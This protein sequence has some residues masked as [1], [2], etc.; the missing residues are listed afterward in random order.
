MWT[1]FWDMHSGGGPKEKG[2]EKIYIEAPEEEAKIIFYNRFK[3]SPDRVSCTCCGRDYSA[4]SNESLAYL[5]AYHR[6]CK[7]SDA[8]NSY[9]E[10][11]DQNFNFL[12]DK[13]LLTLEEYEQKPDV[14]VIRA[15]DI[16]PEE[17]LGEVPEEGYVWR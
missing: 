10:E 4:E 9:V 17:R 11:P 7:W 14:L 8:T 13:K 6:G 15:A 2:Y 3:H 16:K 12:K 5:S 1:Q